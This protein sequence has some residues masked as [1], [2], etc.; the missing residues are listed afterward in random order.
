MNARWQ[1]DLESWAIPDEI[2]RTTTV[3]PWLHNV[4]RMSRRAASEISAPAGPTYDRAR[5]AMGESV[6]DVG[7]GAG[8]ASLPL[9]PAELI[10]VDQ[11]P[12]MLAELGRLRPDA[13]LI[14]GRWPDVEAPEADVVVCAHVVYNVPE[15]AQ[16]LVALDDHARKRVVVELSDVHP[17]SWL[18][19]LWEHFHGLVRPTRPTSD[20]AAEIAAS[21]GFDVTLE[22]RPA[23]EPMF[24]SAE[25]M[26]DSACRRLCLDPSR[27]P[28]VI[29]AAEALG[30]WPSRPRTFI[31]MWWDVRK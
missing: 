7:A 24:P 22:S 11:N 5:Q 9:E 29:A 13:R 21:L 6:L 25:E 27:A 4:Q 12:E 28:E 1:A 17:T 15:L 3:N 8:A 2:L 18:N 31:T 10:A 26:A 30:V 16:F 19:P 20:D 23:P 14:E